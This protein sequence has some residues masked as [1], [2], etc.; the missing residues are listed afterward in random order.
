MHVF[1]LSLALWVLLLTNITV[2]GAAPARYTGEAPVASQTDDDFNAALGVALAQTIVQLTGDNTALSRPNIAK[3]IT[4]ASKYVLQY[5]YRP[6]TTPT[7]GAVEPFILQAQFDGPSIDQLLR[8]SNVSTSQG[9]APSNAAAQINVW[10][11]GLHSAQDYG[12]VMNY[13]TGLSIIHNP[14]V[15]T[16]QPDGVMLKM[17][18]S[19]DE[20]SFLDVIQGDAILKETST[21]DTAASDITLELNP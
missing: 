20:H 17:E 8:Q 6:N 1:R 16:A 10:V 11:R 14:Q 12:R 13:F 7:D 9:D 15:I 21:H 5:Q 19:M 18:I 2:V 3:A 4:E